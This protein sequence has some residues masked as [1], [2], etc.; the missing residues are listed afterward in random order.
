VQSDVWTGATRL[1]AV[2]VTPEHNIFTPQSRD[3][4]NAPF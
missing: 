4:L 2:V 3:T 1:I